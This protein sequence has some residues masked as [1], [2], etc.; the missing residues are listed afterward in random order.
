MIGNRYRDVLNMVMIRKPKEPNNLFFTYL[1]S[2]FVYH[3]ETS[4]IDEAASSSVILEVGR[5]P[6]PMVFLGSDGGSILFL[7]QKNSNNVYAWDT[8]V[9]CL[10]NN[11]KK[12]HHSISCRIPLKVTPGFRDIMWLI[13]SNFMDFANGGTSCVGPLTKLHPMV[14]SEEHVL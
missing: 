14:Y 5:K 4:T 7:R 6:F 10:S 8:N 2:E 12:V 1:T 9:K 3:M 13:E 11:F